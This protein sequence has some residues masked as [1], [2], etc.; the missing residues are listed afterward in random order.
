[1]EGKGSPHQAI[2][3]VQEAPVKVEEVPSYFSPF[4]DL[5]YLLFLH[6][7]FDDFI[8]LAFPDLAKDLNAQI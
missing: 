5:D 7:P 6:L 3:M 4:S 2:V 1:M 8:L